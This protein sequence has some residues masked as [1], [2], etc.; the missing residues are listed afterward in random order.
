[1]LI[2]G[3]YLL[4]LG[5]WIFGV[6]ARVL[7]GVRT[8]IPLGDR[9]V[10]RTPEES[11]SLGIVARPPSTAGWWL[12]LRNSVLTVLGLL[13][14]SM[15]ALPWIADDLLASPLLLKLG[16][17][18]LLAAGI[19]VLLA[20]RVPARVWFIAWLAVLA[21]AVSFGVEVI[22]IR[23]HLDGT[24]AY[25]M[26]TVFKFGLQAWI[27][28]AVAAGAALPWLARGLRRAGPAAQMFGWGLVAGLVS[29]AVVFLLVGI[30]SRLAYRFPE[31]PG[32]TLDGLAFMDR[33][34]YNWNNTDIALR[35]DGEAIR[36]LNTNIRG[37]PIVLQSSLE[38]YRAYG[39]RIA[40]NTGLPTVVSP[41]HANE[42]H[43]PQE[44]AERDRD[45]QQIYYT[46]DTTQALRLLAKYHVGYVYV[47]KIER[48]AYGEA[49]VAK[50]DRLVG[51]YLTVVYR[52]AGVKIYKVN[53]IV[54]SMNAGAD[55]PPP[56]LPQPDEP[57]EVAEQPLADPQADD[58]AL[59]ALEQQVAANP[60][61]SLP[62]FTLAKRYR[63]LNRLDDAAAVLKVAAL[64]NPKDVALHHFWGDILRDAGRADEAEAAY[65]DAIAAKPDAG[66]YNKLG[67]ELAKWGKFDQAIEAFHQAIAADA[68]A[69]EPY[70]HLGEIYEQQGQVDQAIEW[71]RAYLSIASAADPYYNDATAALNRLKK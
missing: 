19:P 58:S 48:T 42:Q 38:F 21:W 46:L 23:D 63:E 10:D 4:I 36:W 8:S 60:T 49:G 68:K 28:M 51:Q 17:L 37:T 56:D 5:L 32:V 45:V 41:L 2:Y 55:M 31:A 62:V 34:V 44:V 40:A 69:L 33:A 7:R 35:D 29:L 26:N 53:P 30:P 11:T 3:L 14:L 65:R 71:Y 15:V 43:D 9:S 64:A 12:V 70:Y 27:L 20:R 61:A 39:V 47:G 54:Y 66:N 25:R 52:N 1:V 24:E 13:V 59:E 6:A 16:L 18:A 22:Y 67:V 57:P 50:F